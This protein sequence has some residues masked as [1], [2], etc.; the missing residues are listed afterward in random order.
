VVEHI[1][2]RSKGGPDT[3]GNVTLACDRCNRL[4]SDLDL[5]PMFLAIAHARAREAAPK[6][7]A[8]HPRRGRGRPPKP[9]WMAV[10]PPEDPPGADL[11]KM[12]RRVGWPV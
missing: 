9:R 7:V 12:L 5:D 1:V 10:Q 2:A 8:R 6:I 3:L 4:K 11:L